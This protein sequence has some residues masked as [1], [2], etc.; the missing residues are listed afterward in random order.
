MADT[1]L[2]NN[3]VQDWL[4]A[5]SAYDRTFKKWEARNEKII[6]RY[7]DDS[8]GYNDPTAK[9]NIL[10]SNV[11][12]IVPAV[13]ARVPKPEVTRRFRDND[14]VGRV[15]SMILQRALAYEVEHYT[16]YRSALNNVVYDRFLGGRGTAWVRYEPKFVTAESPE[17]GLLITEDA[18][19]ADGNEEEGQGE[20]I[21]SECAVVD[22]VHWKDFGHKVA[23]TWEEVTAVWRKV[24][25]GRNALIERF[26]E[27]LGSKIPL[28]TSPES[29]GKKMMKSQEI[30]NQ[31]LV[32]EIWDKES[33]Q[34]IWLSKSM[35]KV[36]DKRDDPL[37]IENF[38][39]C[40]KPLYA[41]ITNDSLEPIPDFSLYQ[42]QAK[43]L[44]LIADRID[45]LVK[46]LKVRGVYDASVPELVRLFSEGED[47]ALLP[48][49]N[50]SAFS[51]KQGLK[52]AI[53]LVDIQP[54]AI[55]LKEAYGAMEQQKQ[56]IYDITGI[57]DII[58]GQTNANETAT[59]QQIK[60][61]YASL[62]LKAMQNSVS[63]F[64]QDLIK[65]KAQIMCKHFSPD[66]L[67]KLACVQQF[68]QDDQQL[69]GPAIQMLTQD[70]MM[71]FRVEIAADSMIQADE[72]Q[73][74]KD[75]VEFLTAAGGFLE[76]A[77]Q[78]GAGVPE[79]VP[80][81]MDML[82]FGITAFKVG[83]T[84]EGEFDKVADEMKQKASQPQQ[85]KPDPEM[86]KIQAG[87]QTE[88]GKMQID[89]AKLQQESQA[90][91][92]RLQM[93][94]QRDQ[95]AMQLKAQTDQAKLQQD[96]QL[97]QMKFQH[98]QFME[99]SRQD[100][101]RWKIEFQESTKITVAEI[102]AKTTMDQALMSAETAANEKD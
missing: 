102:S 19:D 35:G 38:Y 25:L 11:Q 40:P 27:E 60:G 45:G 36:L 12:T 99:Q 61:Q 64:A 77:S 26:G 10:W 18:D 21:E 79:L 65:M 95:S 23:R 2:P 55:A 15:A 46:A 39:P 32:Y 54:I 66:T 59:A 13:Y 53:D 5:I 17:D 52:G 68:S 84:M 63:E 20:I 6:K 31:A 1:E 80:V 67:A 96:A 92:M 100:F 22:Y 72:D 86:M 8:R 71:G 85:Q 14:P 24:Y 89:Q 56:Q 48:V 62:R 44:D 88:Q 37:E 58:R 47:N 51:E 34:V 41:T 81:I 30:D 57:S 70:P 97:E 49:K 33:G 101:E 93:E 82:K 9:F 75:R 69:I 87:Q 43:S 90:S 7:R 73:E 91:Q 98:E 29:D 16:D 78:V 42:D 83:R 50:W 3:E 28:D 76:K 94:Q 4:N 74:K